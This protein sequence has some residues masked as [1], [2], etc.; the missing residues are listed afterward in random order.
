MKPNVLGVI[1]ALISTMLILISNGNML[2]ILTAVAFTVFAA[3]VMKDNS[4]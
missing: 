4:K 1:L 2:I 3:G